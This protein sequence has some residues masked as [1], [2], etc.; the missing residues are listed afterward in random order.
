MSKEEL[1]KGTF[2]GSL[3][4]ISNNLYHGLSNYYSSTA[5]KYIAKNSP[6]HFRAKYIDKIIEQENEPTPQMIL[7]SLVH[8]LTLTPSLT[9]TEFYVLKEEI[10]KRTNAGKERWEYIQSENKDKAIVT[11]ETFNQA[12]DIAIS[13]IQNPLVKSIMQNGTPEKANFWKCPFT[14]L[15][16]KS[17]MDYVTPT[18]LIE[19]KTTT[20]AKLEDFQRTA[21]N[22]YYDISAY[23]YLEGITQTTQKQITEVYFIVVETKAPYVTEVYKASESFL[24]LGHQRWLD[25]V[26]KIEIGT[27]KQIWNG[28]TNTE[29]EGIKEL[30]APKW[31]NIQAED[32]GE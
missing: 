6:I 4:D 1:Q 32:D 11:E 21:Y 30:N 9:N 23:H 25:A 12:S 27:Q 17:K 18:A 13:V 5:I 26:Q 28:Y 3:D 8:S 22:M 15:N 7:G 2:Y 14:N 16:F 20:S 31:A 29:F 19:L 10:N 24:N